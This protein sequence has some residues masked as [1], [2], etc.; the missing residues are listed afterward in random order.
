M[1]SCKTVIIGKDTSTE[2]EES[3]LLGAVTRQRLLKPGKTLRG[4]CA[5][6]Q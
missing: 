3:A 1:R 6:V 2:A 5:V 4:M